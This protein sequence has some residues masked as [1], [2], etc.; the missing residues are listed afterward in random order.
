M[1]GNHLKENASG[2]PGLSLA[3]RKQLSMYLF[4]TKITRIE[5]LSSSI[6]ISNIL[7]DIMSQINQQI[8]I[9]TLEES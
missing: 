6:A 8:N 2:L 9:E 4:S 7:G 1:A 5:M 3:Q